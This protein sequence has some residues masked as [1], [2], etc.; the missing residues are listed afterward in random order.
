[1]PR[2]TSK[3]A[4]F[5]S[6]LTNMRPPSPWRRDARPRLAD[7]DGASLAF[8]S[9]S[10]LRLGRKGVGGLHLGRQNERPPVTVRSRRRVNPVAVATCRF[11][12]ALD[13]SDDLQA[14]VGR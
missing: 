9:I 4:S 7:L 6:P 3:W 14:W 10:A 12:E 13:R 8:G 5:G 1:M 2:P 11:P